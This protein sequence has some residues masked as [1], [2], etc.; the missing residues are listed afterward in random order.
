[1]IVICTRCQA[2]FRV[3]DEKIGPRGAKVRCSKCEAVFVVRRDPPSAADPF[4]SG[5]A[6]PFASP[7]ASTGPFA[8]SPPEDSF[9]PFA[10]APSPEPAVESGDDDPFAAPA[11]ASA[12]LFSQA[13][14]PFA[15]TG[16]APV[17]PHGVGNTLPVTDLSDLLGEPTPPSL[18]SPPR[19][20][21]P[22]APRE[23]F[24]E[25]GEDGL[26]LALEE[27]LTPPPVP[28]GGGRFGEPEPPL[29]P[30]GFEPGAF[31]AFGAASDPD[32]F[33]R[34]DAEVRATTDEVPLALATERTPVA[35]PASPARAVRVARDAAP[36]DGAAPRAPPEAG[37]EAAPAEP[38]HADRI[39]GGR[40]A[41]A[42]SLAVNAAALAV[43]VLVA[44]ALLTAWRA[45]AKLELASLRPGAVLEALRGG[46]PETFGAEQVSSGI[47]EREAGPP[48]L[49]VR[50]VAASHAA[51]PVVALRVRVEV[52][53]GGGVIARGE[54]LAGAVP[55][56]EELHGAADGAALAAVVGAAEARRPRQIRGG[57]AV[58]FLVVIADQ[59]ADLAGASLHVSVEAARAP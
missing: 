21:P 25:G 45:G 31:G 32:A 30:E 39:P 55:T 7:A 11:S 40:A 18:R 23:A 51:A 20:P 27:R 50:G 10:T 53:R 48:I 6:D 8:A 13:S 14:D 58:P 42:R 41:R 5:E 47:Y 33:H 36:A 22:P 57:E 19:L 49:F 16:T 34:A 56:A 1:M 15:A 12:S 37:P 46:A 17:V 9:A 43:L 38:P 54:A 24:G 52:T 44:F 28:A 4:A 3:A 2:K 35:Q 29:P 26:G 59:P